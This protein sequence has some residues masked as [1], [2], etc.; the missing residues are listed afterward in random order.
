MRRR[1]ERPVEWLISRI[2]E[3]GLASGIEEAERLDPM[4]V[5]AIFEERYFAYAYEEM[6]RDP[7]SITKEREEYFETMERL[8]S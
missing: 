2:C 1:G 6:K 5:D 8:S 7:K 3:A 4:L